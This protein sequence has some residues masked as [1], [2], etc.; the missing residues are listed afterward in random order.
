MLRRSQVDT[1]LITDPIFAEAAYRAR[2]LTNRR[3]RILS[4]LHFS[5]DKL[6]NVPSL[7]KA[8]GHLAISQGIKRQLEAI[9][10]TTPIHVVH[11]PLS[12]NF[13]PARI[14]PSTPGLLL[15]VG[16]LNNRQKRLDVLFHALSQINDSW[17]LDI[18]GDGPDSAWLQNMTHELGINGKVAFKGW[19]P[20]PWGHFQ[21]SALVLTSDF[22]GFPMVLVEAL[23]R[24]IPVIST[25]CPTGPED[26]VENHKNGLLAEAGSVA[27]VRDAVRVALEQEW[28]WEWTPQAIQHNALKHYNASGVFDHMSTAI[29]SIPVR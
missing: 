18:A 12:Y 6:A 11:N 21:P 3:I 23:A 5:L 19:Q 29:Q 26:I 7:A 8:D 16:R 17:Q 24:G 4:W 10:I 15:Y 22:E 20:D 1:L 27:S 2:Y 14:Q 9:N 13:N 25:N 28:P